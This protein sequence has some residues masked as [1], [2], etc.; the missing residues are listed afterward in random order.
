MFLR[1]RAQL[2]CS[3]DTKTG[4]LGMFYVL[5]M[6]TSV[7]HAYCSQP[8]QWYVFQASALVSVPTSPSGCSGSKSVGKAVCCPAE[9]VA[10]SLLL[11]NPAKLRRQQPSTPGLRVEGN[12]FVQVQMQYGYILLTSTI[13]ADL[14]NG[15]CEGIVSAINARA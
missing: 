14:C 10:S 12:R 13:A 15:V 1:I 2:R 4:D 11:G 7:I 6:N 8:S 3:K 9:Y 5:V